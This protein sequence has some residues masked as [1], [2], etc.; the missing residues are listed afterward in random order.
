M[1]DLKNVQSDSESHNHLITPDDFGPEY[2]LQVSDPSVGLRGF[3]VVDNTA[4]GP[5][6][7]GIRMTRTVTSEEVFRLARA[8]TWKNSLAGIPFGGAKAGIVWNPPSKILEDKKKLKNYK[9]N[10][11]Q[12]FARA[13]KPLL[14]KKYIGGPDVSSGEEEMRWFAEAAGDWRAST[15]KPKSYLF[16]GR[17]GLPHELGSTGYGVAESSRVAMRYAGLDIKGATVAI[18]GFGNV[19]T[20]AYQFLTGMG[21]KV[22]A[23]ANSRS[24]VYSPDGFPKNKVLSAIKK[25]IPIDQQFADRKIESE[26]FWSLPV[27][28]LIPAS[29]TDVIHAGNC[30]GIKAKVIVEG[31]NIPM[32]EDIEQR[33]AGKGILIVPDIVANSG[34]VISSYAEY[35]GYDA[36]RMFKLVKNKVTEATE[37]VLSSADGKFGNLREIAMRLAKAKVLSARKPRK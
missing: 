26:D 12:A 14:I 9:K 13:L 25:H 31:A 30:D 29:V 1:S 27:D 15:G 28:L 34:G 37:L 23:I 32:R 16:K 18:H 3:L 21:A 7:G 22:V 24:A 4:L 20:F 35:R 11:V 33:L 5:G 10:L 2:V 6:K 8:M 19:G 36:E 17:G